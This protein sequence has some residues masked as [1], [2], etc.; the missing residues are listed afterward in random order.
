MSQV[1]R[2]NRVKSKTEL[3]SPRETILS[4]RLFAHT[5][6]ELSQSSLKLVI[7]TSLWLP[8]LPHGT[9]DLEVDILSLPP[10]LSK[11]TIRSLG[12]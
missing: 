1:S 3:K 4:L 9:I 5:A 10:L 2:V 12:K 11:M 8:S 6:A 7:G